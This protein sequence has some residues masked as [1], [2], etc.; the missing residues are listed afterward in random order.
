MIIF[1]SSFISLNKQGLI[2][3]KDI[4]NIKISWYGNEKESKYFVQKSVSSKS[5]MMRVFGM[6]GDSPVVDV[7]SE[8]G[9]DNFWNLISVIFLCI[10]IV[11]YIIYH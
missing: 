4:L 11:F 8:L 3:S 1:S 5:K 2:S 10:K 9:C 7:V 6:V